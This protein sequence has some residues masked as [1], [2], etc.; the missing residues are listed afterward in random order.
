MHVMSNLPYLFFII[1]LL[2]INFKRH[3]LVYAKGQGNKT[4]K[5]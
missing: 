1:F 5:K 4:E 3:K 2:F